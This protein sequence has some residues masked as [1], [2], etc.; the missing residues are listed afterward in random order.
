MHHAVCKVF[1]SP[2][3]IVLLSTLLHSTHRTPIWKVH[4]MCGTHHWMKVWHGIYIAHLYSASISHVHIL[5][6]VQKRDLR[7]VGDAQFPV[8]V[9]KL[10]ELDENKRVK[11]VGHS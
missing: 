10:R 11:K 6:E 9:S 8:S 4:V 1:P 7:T 3:L 2:E 5:L